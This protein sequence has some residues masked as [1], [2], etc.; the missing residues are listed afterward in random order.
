MDYLIRFSN[1]AIN[2]DSQDALVHEMCNEENSETESQCNICLKIYKNKDSLRK[3]KET[4]KHYIN[5]M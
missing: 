5:A 2:V 4:H 1:E 3:H